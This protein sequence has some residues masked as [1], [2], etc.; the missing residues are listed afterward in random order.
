MSGSDH[1]NRSQARGTPT[2]DCDTVR[3]R[4]PELVEGMLNERQSEAFLISHLEACSY[5]MTNFKEAV[6]QATG[7]AVDHLLVGRVRGPLPWPL[8]GVVAVWLKYL[9]ACNRDDD[10]IGAVRAL[11]VLARLRGIEGDEEEARKLESLATKLSRS[12]SVEKAVVETEL[13]QAAAEDADGAH[14]GLHS[15]STARPRYRD[16]AGKWWTA[17]AAVA[18]VLLV[19]AVFWQQTELSRRASALAVAVVARDA[20]ESRVRA[21]EANLDERQDLADPTRPPRPSGPRG[22]AGPPGRVEPRVPT[23]TVVSI[24]RAMTTFGGGSAQ[25]APVRLPVQLPRFTLEVELAALRNDSIVDATLSR[26]A[27]IV[28]KADLPVLGGRERP[29]IRIDLDAEDI[30]RLFPGPVRLNLVDR[31]HASIASYE[32]VFG[33]HQAP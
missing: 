2:R 5:C 23:A 17:L 31:G 13:D 18:A 4:L 7:I 1:V 22:P 8:A 10:Q 9:H 11:Q 14:T 33:S 20:A 26:E 6:E 19:G 16:R 15:P 12:R 29:R 32:L 24:P 30:A 21:L 25:V 27:V 3:P 28:P